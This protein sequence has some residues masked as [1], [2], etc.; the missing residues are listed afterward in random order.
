M[1]SNGT[2]DLDGFL[3]GVVTTAED[4]AALARV[5]SFNYLE[6]VEYLGFLMAFADLHPPDREIPPRHEPFVL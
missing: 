2:P 4:V 1:R 3:D 5:R 6:P